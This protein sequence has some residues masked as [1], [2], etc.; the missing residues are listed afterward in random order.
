MKA[1][2]DELSG[3]TAVVTGAG[4]GIGRAIALELTRA[5]ARVCVVG[6]RRDR[7]ETTC[8]SIRAE[9]GDA[10]FVVADLREPVSGALADELARDDVLVNNAADFAPYGPLESVS[11]A[12]TSRVLDTIVTATLRLTALALPS[13]KA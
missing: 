3:R 2:T 10:T 13:M 12:D 5:G 7:L 1:R 11:A 8:D 9:N 4:R 6:R